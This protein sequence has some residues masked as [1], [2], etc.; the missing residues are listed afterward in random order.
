MFYSLSTLTNGLLQGIDKLKIP[1]KNAAI[2]LVAHVILLVSL[3]LF[4]RLNIYAVVIANAFF[5]FL[6]C[7]LNAFELQRHSGY[8]QEFQKTFIIPAISSILMGAM[9]YGC[10]TLCYYLSKNNLVSI[11]VSIVIAIIVY[12]VALLLFKGLTEEEIS[13]FPKGYLLVQVAKKMHLLK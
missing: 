1:V 13:K 7:I 4:F 8:K 2:A 9:A 5:A 3:M 11:V 12:A 6:V 10:F